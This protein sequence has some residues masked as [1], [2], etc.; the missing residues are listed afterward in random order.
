M[1]HTSSNCSKELR[2]RVF[3]HDSGHQANA[4]D[5]GIVDSKR[6]SAAA[7]ESDLY[8]LLLAG[9]GAVK[10]NN[11]GPEPVGT[12]S[13]ATDGSLKFHNMLQGY[14]HHYLDD[15][16]VLHKVRLHMTRAPRRS[17]QNAETLLKGFS[18]P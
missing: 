8:C 5:R 11:G 6:K 13:I 1:A 7:I 12:N 2:K 3:W 9:S 16:Q 10:R 15:Q 14:S 18:V 4:L 17:S